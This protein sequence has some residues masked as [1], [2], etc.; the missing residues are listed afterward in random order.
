MCGLILYVSE[1]D[2]DVW[3]YYIEQ[4]VLGTDP[5][6]TKALSELSS[7]KS[8]TCAEKVGYFYTSWEMAE[9]NNC[10]FSLKI[11]GD[12]LLLCEIILNCPGSTGRCGEDSR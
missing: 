5:K 12:K 11:M 3:D 9:K 10:Q 1:D 7:N 2:E 4:N 6:G 8:L